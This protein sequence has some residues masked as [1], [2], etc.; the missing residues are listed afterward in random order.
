M[1]PYLI[2]IGCIGASLPHLGRRLI[3][4]G[5]QHFNGI[6]NRRHG[7]N[8]HHSATFYLLQVAT[9]WVI[10]DVSQHVVEGLR[11]IVSTVGV[12]N[13][14]HEHAPLFEHNLLAT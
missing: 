4:D 7:R 3:L 9:A 8:V 12:A 11:P 1:H 14:L 2:Y 6:A 10:G 5:A 13:K